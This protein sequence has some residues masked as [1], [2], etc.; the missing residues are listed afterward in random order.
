MSKR[1]EP[2]SERMVREGG[3]ADKVF[4]RLVVLRDL[5]TQEE[6]DQCR[7]IQEGRAARG[8]RP[9]I[10]SILV[11][12]GILSRS[13]VS[14]LLEHQA[15]R[16]R[17]C[18]ECDALVE[19]GGKGAEQ[20]PV[21][22]AVVSDGGPEGEAGTITSVTAAGGIAPPQDGSRFEEAETILRDRPALPKDP[23]S[24]GP[25]LVRRRPLEGAAPSGPAK[26]IVRHRDPGADQ[27]DDA[28]ATLT[29]VPAL[30]DE[31]VWDGS[32]TSAGVPVPEK[33]TPGDAD[34][35]ATRVPNDPDETGTRAPRDAD[36]T[37]TRDP[38]RTGTRV[39]RDADETAT[40]TPGPDEPEIHKAIPVATDDPEGL[41]GKVIGGCEI[42]AML[43]KGG[44]G[45]VYRA[46]RLSLKKTVALKLMPRSFCRSP[47]A[48]KR[49]SR[50]ARSAGQLLHPNI[51]QVF[52]IGD[53]QG[54]HYIEMEFVDGRSLRDLLEEK[55]RLATDDLLGIMEPAARAL[56]AA[57]REGVI[58]RDIKP[59][60]IMLA[61]EGVLKIADFGLARGMEDS[62]EVTREGQV[63]G[64]PHYMSPE[65]CEGKTLDHR[66]DI[67]SL[68][69]TF[70]HMATGQRPF[71]GDSAVVI[72]RKHIQEA[73]PPPRQIAPDLPKGIC[74][75]I[76]RMMEKDVEDR[77]QGMAEV[78]LD[79]ERL[80]LGRKLEGRGAGLSRA[81]TRRPSAWT[82]PMG[83]ILTLG[84][85]AAV[86]AGSWMSSSPPPLQDGQDRPAQVEPAQKD[87]DEDGGSAAAGLVGEAGAGPD[88]GGS[89]SAGIEGGTIGETD[90]GAEEPIGGAE[91]IGE[92]E[93]AEAHGD[94]GEP[95]E[96]NVV[97]EPPGPAI[98]PE[99][100]RLL[101]SWH[102]QARIVGGGRYSVGT[103]EVLF[104][105]PER[106]VDLGPFEISEHEVTNAEYQEFL[107]AGG[108]E[109]PAYWSEEA[110]ERVDAL[111]EEETGKRGPA[112]WKDGR[113]PKGEG[114]HPV[115]GVSFDE[116]SA[117]CAWFASMHPE[118]SG[119][120][121]PREDEWEVAASWGGAE[122]P[123]RDYPWGDDWDRRNANVGTGSAL[124][125]G[126]K[127]TDS[128]L[129][130]CRDM[131][132]NVRE[133]A[134]GSL[135][136]SEGMPV[137]RG[138]CFLR[139]ASLKSIA[140]CESRLAPKG[141]DEFRHRR[142]NYMG[143]RVV[144]PGAAPDGPGEEEK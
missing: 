118:L 46:R 85:A 23:F 117:Y 107:R 1:A 88:G 84:L 82:L 144:L 125:V 42:S 102:R 69:V 108:Y 101:L 2:G 99:G 28:R 134:T 41:I 98:S 31:N 64:T 71:A 52:N 45:A 131:A 140:R 112:L 47:D 62:L 43:G 90:I 19:V 24:E 130:G 142:R 100:E 11:E 32:E 59:D 104:R 67:Y 27:G 127:S 39:P 38:D 33:E 61:H 70:Y 139:V 91:T 120:R 3:L 57:H 72:L 80:K 73:A 65:Q 75:L 60:N 66:S 49:F 34:R 126:K 35:T 5:A 51:V 12:R 141:D 14:R 122:E 106:E 53:D 135:P 29:T 26:M 109:N 21:C 17:V 54:Y 128:S 136:G 137:Q 16:I 83:A 4:A 50:E 77:Y 129:V 40:R 133:W 22:R 76:E 63:L 87:G 44:M 25:T 9:S 81:G 37:G 89:E 13:Q 114:Q 74:S 116:A 95:E 58:H 96:A 36:E 113:F 119:A 123:A 20:C 92:T 124:P 68:G 30:P 7:G 105:S 93:N 143:F 94:G 132:G 79:I 121:L 6:V 110:W 18:P 111:V 115:T 103:R 55:G 86:F 78:I 56:E 8:V 97:V 138:G 15:E 10:D 48:V